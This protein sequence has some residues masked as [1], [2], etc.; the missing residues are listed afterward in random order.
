[1]RVAERHRLRARTVDLRNSGDTAGPQSE[2]VGYGAWVFEQSA[3]P[4]EA[5]TS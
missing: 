5:M 1:L 3:S 2:V 4:I